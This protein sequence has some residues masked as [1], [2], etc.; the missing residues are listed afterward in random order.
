MTGKKHIQKAIIYGFFFVYAF[1]V[2]KPVLPVINDLLAHA[3]FNS[4]H[5]ATVHYE[6]GAYHL[7]MELKVESD[8]QKEKSK[9]NAPASSSETLANH[10]NV[11][12]NALNIYRSIISINFQPLTPSTHDGWVYKTNPPPRA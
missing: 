7:H 11:K 3:F 12:T 5:L 1:A 4:H 10:L 6:N 8:Q 9:E 2:L